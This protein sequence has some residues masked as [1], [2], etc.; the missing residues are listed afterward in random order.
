MTTPMA[1]VDLPRTPPPP[2]DPAADGLR[3]AVLLSARRFKSTW[4][5]LG[6]LLTQVRDQALFDGWGYPSFEAYCLAELRIRKQTALK[7]TRSFSFLDKH[8][9]QALERPELREAAPPFEVVEVLAGAEERGQLSAQDYRSV[10][11]AI[12][13]PDRPVSELKRELTDRFPAPEVRVSSA[14]EL[15]RL[16]GVARRLHGELGAHRK[17][18]RDVVQTAEDLCRQ[19]EGLLVE[20]G[21]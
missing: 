12:W 2:F 17:V 13:N 21:S 6:K 11:D 15:K 14:Q 10:R 5:E 3:H 16:W 1:S 19:L 8:E 9:P 18:P 4:V 20:A 7:L